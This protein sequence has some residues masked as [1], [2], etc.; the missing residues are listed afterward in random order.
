MPNGEINGNGNGDEEENGRPDIGFVDL[1]VASTCFSNIS[2]NP[3]T[4]QL[5]MTFIKDGK[6]YIIDGIQEFDVNNWLKSDSAGG[7]FNAFI[8]GN[9]Y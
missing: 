6:T 5:S 1:H 4:E 2:Y 3:K 8:R 7:H 9:F